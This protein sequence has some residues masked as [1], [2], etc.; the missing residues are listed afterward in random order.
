MGLV[1]AQALTWAAVFATITNL[2]VRCVFYEHR[3]C[4]V[5]VCMPALDLQARFKKQKRK[6]T[7]EGINWAHPRHQRVGLT[8]P[9]ELGWRPSSKILYQITAN[10]IQSSCKMQAPG[11]QQS[12]VART[13][14]SW[15]GQAP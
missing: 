6:T 14:A 8:S 1:R 11:C 12:L 5:S 9:V 2:S 15:N 3:V 13:T 4:W 7:Q 10:V